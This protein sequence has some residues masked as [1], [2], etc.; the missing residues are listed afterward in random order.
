MQQYYEKI[1]TE[2]ERIKLE[3]R[4]LELESKKFEAANEEQKAV[5]RQIRGST[6]MHQQM[7]AILARVSSQAKSKSFDVSG[8]SLH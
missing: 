1:S 6:I 5:M 7:V 8:K 2:K 4:R 3:K